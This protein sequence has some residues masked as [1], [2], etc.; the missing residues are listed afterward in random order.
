MSTF[1]KLSAALLGTAVLVVPG[2]AL[3]ST[4]SSSSS[5]STTASVPALSPGIVAPTIDTSGASKYTV[6]YSNSV[7]SSDAFSVGT[8]TNIGSSVSASSTPDYDVTSGATFG[9]KGSV[10]EQIIGTAGVSTTNSTN[11]VSDIEKQ[12]ESLATSQMER[13]FEKIQNTTTS[14][15]RYRWRNRRTKKVTEINETEYNE[16]KE[17]YKMELKSDITETLTKASA[18]TGTISGSFA[19]SFATDGNSNDVTVNGIGT[20]AKITSADASTFNSDIKKGSGAST[21]AG[22]ASGSAAGSVGTTATANA[23]SSQ[24][25]SSFA[26]AY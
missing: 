19:K 21:G 1:H 4:P 18:K 20:N 24:F 26:Q 5:G 9:V 16:A 22:T 6:Q 25:V 2:A 3:A 12:S 14:G 8:N 7:G 10:I 17:T 15:N 13:D 11:T 23:N